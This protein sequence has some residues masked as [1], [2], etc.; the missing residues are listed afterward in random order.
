[1]RRI[2]GL[3]LFLA[4]KIK[5]FRSF[6]KVTI[7]VRFLIVLGG[8]GE[9]LGRGLGRVWEGFGEC[10]GLILVPKCYLGVRVELGCSKNVGE[11]LFGVLG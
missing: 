7:F 4:P 11:H 2:W 3:G 10:F 9:G 5:I 6:F 1:M 8:F